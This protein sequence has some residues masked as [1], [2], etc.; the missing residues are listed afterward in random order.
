MRF[1]EWWKATT[2][3]CRLRDPRWTKK[4]CHEFWLLTKTH[5][6]AGARRILA[7]KEPQ[8]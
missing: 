7:T 5:G 4:Q 2:G 6:E 3:E 8:S 1:R